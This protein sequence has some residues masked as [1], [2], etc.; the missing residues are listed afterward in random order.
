MRQ[1]SF[2]AMEEAAK[3]HIPL[4]VL[5]RPNPIG[6]TTVDG[7]PLEKEHRSFIGYLDIP[8]CH[9]MTIGE[10]AQYFNSEYNIG[11][12]LSIVPMKGW[13]RSM[14][15]A[16]T[17]LPWTPTSPQVPEA[18]TPLY[19]ATTGIIGELGLVSIGIGY[20]LPF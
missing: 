11:C 19:Y 20:T 13:K 4:I 5:D 12:E 3:H 9:G 1:R 2:F 10:L 7:P 8:Y 18:D 14:H 16:Q 17:K 6:G 15:F